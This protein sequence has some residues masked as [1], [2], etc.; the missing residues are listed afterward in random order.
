MFDL[1]SNTNYNFYH[2]PDD[3]P[4]CGFLCIYPWVSLS[5]LILYVEVFTTFEK[6]TAIFSSNI[7][8]VQFLV[9]FF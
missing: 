1:Q 8:S 6:F 9:L 5:F 7:A 3:V 4:W 2:H